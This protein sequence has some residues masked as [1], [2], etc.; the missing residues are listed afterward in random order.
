MNIKDTIKVCEALA[1]KQLPITPFLWGRHGLGKSSAIKQLGKKLGYRVLSIILSQKEAVDVA[2]VLYTFKDDELGI[3]VTAA[4]PPQWFADAL[5]NGKLILFLD[6]FNMARKEV[7]NAAFELVLDR[8]LNNNVLPDSV[9]IVAAGNPDDERYDCTPMSESLRDRFMHIKVTADV[10]GWIAFAKKANSNIHP[11]V[12]SFIESDPKAAYVE[13]KLDERF[14]VEIKHSF[15]SW[16]RAGMIHDLE[17]SHSLKHECLSGIVGPELAKAFMLH[18]GAK[19]KPLTVEEILGFNE[20]SKKKLARF[21]SV[22][23]K[24]GMRADLVTA[25]V[26]NLVRALTEDEARVTAGLPKV[27]EFFSALPDDVLQSAISQTYR[28]TAWFEAIVGH[29]TLRARCEE[30]IKATAELEKSEAA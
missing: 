23:E 1:K 28:V 8:R 9:F 17:L 12:V 3:S 18:H 2:G 20:A 5:K 7:M 15:R 26:D 29:P 6:E 21:C 13:D 30:I 22:D 16:E 4:H 14:P 10:N 27:L 24:G 11:D 19:D 25:S